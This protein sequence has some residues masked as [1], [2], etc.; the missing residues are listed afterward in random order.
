MDEVWKDIECYEGYYQISNL[1]N[2]RSLDRYIPVRNSIGRRFIKGRIVPQQKRIARGEEGY[3]TVS[4]SKFGKNTLFLVHRLVAKAFIP[5]PNNFPDVNHKDEDKH[6]NHVSNLEWCT[7]KYNNTY[8][9]ARERSAAKTRKKL[10]SLICMVTFL[11][12][13]KV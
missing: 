10:L 3:C 1:G 7:T 2:V 5:N 8:G 12:R 4:L 11:K 6:N 13:M 9:T